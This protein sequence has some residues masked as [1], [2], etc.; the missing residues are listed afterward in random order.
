MGARH[1]E[2]AENFFD[3]PAPILVRATIEELPW[4]I[5]FDL[6]NYFGSEFADTQGRTYGVTINTGSVKYKV[7]SDALVELQIGNNTYNVGGEAGLTIEEIAKRHP[8]VRQ[9]V[10]YQS[11]GMGPFARLSSTTIFWHT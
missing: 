4:D 9:K 2:T 11:P 8:R 1:V 10:S 5:E 7:L 6:D 3:G